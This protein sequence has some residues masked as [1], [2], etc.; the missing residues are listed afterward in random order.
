MSYPATP[1]NPPV[2]GSKNLLPGDV[3]APVPD[4][5]AEHSGASGSKMVD[6]T[7]TDG[8]WAPGFT[9][10][11]DPEMTAAGG[12]NTPNFASG[13]PAGIDV[14]PFGE[15]APGTLPDRRNVS[16]S[17]KADQLPNDVNAPAVTVPNPVTGGSNTPGW[18]GEG[19]P[20]SV[21]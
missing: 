13:T 3:N 11:R 10:D 19:K 4:R 7:R 14:G 5:L 20:S 15:L 16:S 12:D 18:G 21:A 6:Y 8:K 1:A 2:A 17:P 9:K